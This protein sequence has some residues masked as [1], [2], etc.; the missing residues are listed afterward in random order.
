[1]QNHE[2]QFANNQNFANYDQ[3]EYKIGTALG[4]CAKSR[5]G[6]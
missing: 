5:P 6:F 1:M 2:L 3:I 4:L